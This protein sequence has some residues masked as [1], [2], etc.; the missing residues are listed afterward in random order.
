MAFHLL[1][2]GQVIIQPPVHPPCFYPDIL[3]DPPDFAYTFT[4]LI[5]DLF[6][7]VLDDQIFIVFWETALYNK[8]QQSGDEVSPMSMLTALIIMTIIYIILALIIR[9]GI[10][11]SAVGHAQS[12]KQTSRSASILA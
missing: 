11:N 5:G 9:K 10:W 1:L 3:L 7:S 8:T 4:G 6:R 2:S 12:G